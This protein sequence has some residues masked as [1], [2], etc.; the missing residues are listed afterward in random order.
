MIFACPKDEILISYLNTVYFGSG[1]YGIGAAARLYFDKEVAELTLAESGDA[2][3]ARSSALAIQPFAR[4]SGGACPSR[5]RSQFHGGKRRNRRKD[6]RHHQGEPGGRFE[7]LPPAS[8]QTKSWFADW[9]AQE[10]TGTS[11]ARPARSI[12][13]R[14]TIDPKIQALAEKTVSG[15]CLPSRVPQAKASQAALVAMRPNGAVIAMVGGRDY[16]TSQFNRATEANR[17]PGS[18]FKVFVYL[19]ALR[20]GYSPQDSIDASP[21]AIKNWTPENFGGA[22]YGQVTLADALTRSINTA[23]VRLAVDVG[24]KDV[25]KAARDLG[26]EARMQPVPSLALG[27]VEG[28]SPRHDRG[29]RL[30]TRWTHGARALGHSG[31]RGRAAAFT[32]TRQGRQSRVLLNPWDR[33]ISR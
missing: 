9:I 4:W 1:A 6:G 19:A 24:L 23:A 17:H 32:C 2:R 3:W 25:I 11:Q 8:A 18:A 10:A 14:T 31:V 13:V 21:L 15:R 27:A 30:F 29:F 22:Q 5:G 20:K 26:I 7:V 33:R 28:E 16:R 12:R